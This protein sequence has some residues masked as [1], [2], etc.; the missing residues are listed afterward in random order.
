M[1]HSLFQNSVVFLPAVSLP[2]AA[3]EVPTHWPFW[4]CAWGKD[5]RIGTRPS[6]AKGH[7]GVSLAIATAQTA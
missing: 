1:K 5:F 3:Q 6:D 2:L 7:E 4:T